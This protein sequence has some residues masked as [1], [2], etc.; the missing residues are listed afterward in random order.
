MKTIVFI[1][2]V[3]SVL[4]IALVVVLMVRREQRDMRRLRDTC[5][6]FS[7]HFESWRIIS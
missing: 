2:I 3:V 5:I 4:L 1:G 7:R 6:G